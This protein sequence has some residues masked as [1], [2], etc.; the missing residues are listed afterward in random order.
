[1]FYSGDMVGRPFVKIT[2]P[3]WSGQLDVWG[4]ADTGWFGLVIW[5]EYVI[6]RRRG[7]SNR[8]QSCAAW[9]AAEHLAP[10]QDA[11]YAHVERI[12]LPLNRRQWPATQRPARGTLAQRRPMPGVMTG[13]PV[14]LPAH[15][16]KSAHQSDAGKH[17]ATVRPDWAGR[18]GVPRRRARL[19]LPARDFVYRICRMAD[20]HWG[21]LDMR[22]MACSSRNAAQ[23]AERSH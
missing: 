12:Q 21:R 8:A 19:S 9:I 17:A 4:R 3:P 7:P 23:R 20:V 14:K 2:I 10:G 6:D 16:Q 5:R 11:S 15:Y 22:S 13:G 18:T 1:M